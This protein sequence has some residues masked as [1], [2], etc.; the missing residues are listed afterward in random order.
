MSIHKWKTLTEALKEVEKEI[1]DN[2]E[3]YGVT[4]EEWLRVCQWPELLKS[5]E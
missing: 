2:P 3:E 4:R 1:Y 5:E